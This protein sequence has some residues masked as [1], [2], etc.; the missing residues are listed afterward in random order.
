MN[1]KITTQKLMM[2]LAIGYLDIIEL[3][4]Q[5]IAKGIEVAYFKEKKEVAVEAY[6]EV[7]SGLVVDVMN[8]SQSCDEIIAA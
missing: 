5:N 6:A 2:Q 4:E 3:C 8:N 1:A 7:M